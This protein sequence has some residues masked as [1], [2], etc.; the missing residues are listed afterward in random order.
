MHGG[1][2]QQRMLDVVAGKDGD[3][4]VGR[5]ITFRSDAAIA[6]TATSVSA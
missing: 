6:F 5:Q 2:R 4:T 1:E 3:R